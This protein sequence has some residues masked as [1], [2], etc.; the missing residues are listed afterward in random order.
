MRS[1]ARAIGDSSKS[2]IR[3][4][5]PSFV[6]V[7]IVRR[8]LTAPT[9]DPVT[10]AVSNTDSLVGFFTGILTKPVSARRKE[11]S[12][13][14]AYIGRNVRRL[15]CYYGYVMPQHGDVLHVWEY[16]YLSRFSAA[17]LPVPGD[18][19]RAR[20]TDAFLCQRSGLLG[21]DLPV[22]LG[23]LLHAPRG[24]AG[25]DHVPGEWVVLPP[26]NSGTIVK[27]EDYAQIGASLCAIHLEMA[28]S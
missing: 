26:T 16:P 21:I 19:P 11:E 22:S 4:L 2:V 13:K 20:N 14:D 25:G 9:F 18:L 23:H 17:V 6:P 8:S 27:I 10:M 24:S 5:E 12:G 7:G 1:I 3:A 15:L 28:G